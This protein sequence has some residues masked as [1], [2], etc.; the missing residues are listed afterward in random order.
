MP[1]TPDTIRVFRVTHGLSQPEL[2]RL[3]SVGLR[4]VNRWE[5]GAGQIP[6]FL[7]R[8]LRDLERDLI[9]NQK[10]APSKLRTNA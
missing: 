8:A 10:K 5:T 1:A 6:A 9:A 2:A 3:L 4:T 7:H